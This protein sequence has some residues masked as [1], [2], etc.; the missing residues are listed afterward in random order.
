MSHLPKPAAVVMSVSAMKSRPSNSSTDEPGKC[1]PSL[2]ALTPGMIS[3]SV[4]VRALRCADGVV[5]QRRSSDEIYT[6]H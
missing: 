4:S 3:V 6:G 5:V 2:M 1:P